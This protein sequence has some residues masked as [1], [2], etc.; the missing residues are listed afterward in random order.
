MARLIKFARGD[1]PS[2]DV[3][4][5]FAEDTNNGTLTVTAK[6]ST[7]A[8]KVKWHGA[9]SAAPL[10]G[11]TTNPISSTYRVL[12][13]NG[14]QLPIES[15]VVVSRVAPKQDANSVAANLSMSENDMKAI[16][17]SDVDL[18][19][20]RAKRIERDTQVYGKAYVKSAAKPQRMGDEEVKAKD[21]ERRRKRDGSGACVLRYQRRPGG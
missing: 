12:L 19:N 10:A 17:D 2:L 15:L 18:R 3:T 21:Q 11:T 8:N 13:P 9:V 16:K 14:E 1:A 5:N 7:G 6:G 4:T 20:V